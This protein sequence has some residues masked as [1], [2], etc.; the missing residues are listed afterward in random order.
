MDIMNSRLTQSN[1]LLDALIQPDGAKFYRCALQVNPYQYLIKNSKQTP[2]ES[3]E[4]YNSAIIEACILNQIDAIA[5]TDHFCVEDSVSLVQLARSRGIYAFGGFEATSKEGVHFLCLY[6]REKDKDLERFIGKFGVLTGENVPGSK[7]CEELLECVKSQGGIAIAAHIINK[8]GLLKHLSGQTCMKIWK[9]SL[10]LACAIPGPVNDVPQDF[11]NIINNRN[12]Q[13]NR[14][15]PMAFLNAS[16]VNSPDDLLKDSSITSIKMSDI[17]VEGLRQAFLDPDSRIR[18]DNQINTIHAQLVAIAWE[19][20]FLDKTKIHFSSNLNVLIGGRGVGKSTIVESIR[21]VLGLEPIGSDALKTHLEFVKSVLKSGTKVSM[22]VKAPDS[23]NHYYTIER[24]VQNQPVITDESGELKNISPRDLLPD[25]QVFGQHEIS[26]LTRNKEK[27][28]QLLDRFVL[29]EGN[30]QSTKSKLKHELEN[31]R[32]RIVQLQKELTAIEERLNVLP[33]MEE[34]LRRYQELGLENKLKEKSLYIREEQ[35]LH[36]IHS[37]MEPISQLRQ[38][39]KELL[40]IDAAFV[41]A[42]ALEGLPNSSLLHGSSSILSQITSQLEMVGKEIDTI[43]SNADALV[44]DI[45]QRWQNNKTQVEVTYQ[46]MLRELQGS[47]IDGAEFI[48][49]RRQIEELTPLQERKKL[50]EH[51]MH[52]VKEQRSQLLNEWQNLLSTDYKALEKASKLVTNKLSGKVHVSVVCSGNL[53]PLEIFLRDTVGGQLK[54]QIDKLKEYKSLSLVD[55]AQRCREGKDSLNSSYG[56]TGSAIDKLVAAEPEVLMKLEEIEL[57]AI[58]D[59][60]LNIST[61][62]DKAVWIDLDKLSTGQKAT[63]ILLLLLLES[64]SPLIVDQPEDDL[65]NRFITD[66]I[67]PIMKEKKYKRQ[68]IFSTH[69]A[70]IPVLGDAENIIGLT[71]NVSNSELYGHVN[72]KHSG[73]I[74]LHP[75]RIMVEEILE[76]GKTAFETRREKYGF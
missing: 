11:K 42:R 17:S 14:D 38:N 13:Y 60:K 37:R 76:G 9:S 1:I 5:V 67:V 32:I 29:R 21:Y 73:S 56:L 65:D 6:D 66:S 62:G 30:F 16:D 74:D 50:L 15:R 75:V 27:L 71:S 41:S 55:L 72:P 24:T 22:L 2:Y 25:I 23:L 47:S 51:N 54:T 39:L 59:I 3:E 58:T 61:A 19:G 63:A 33:V 10:L 53:D 52:I 68:F 28:T 44:N 20:G 26:E 31:S 46:E 34:R 70:N 43:I 57:P 64:E 7:D 8:N 12:H 49:L 35:I 45:E 36:T 4:D 40:P 69:N 48:T 18:L